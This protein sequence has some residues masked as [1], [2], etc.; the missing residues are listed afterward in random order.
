[1]RFGA[2]R[3]S[4]IQDFGPPAWENADLGAMRWDTA[5]FSLFAM[6][7]DKGIRTTASLQLPVVKTAREQLR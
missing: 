6:L 1:L 4:L 2:S 7:S 3:E 5:Q